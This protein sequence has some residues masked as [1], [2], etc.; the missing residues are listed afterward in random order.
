MEAKTTAGSDFITTDIFGQNPFERKGEMYFFNPAVV[1][2]EKVVEFFNDEKSINLIF[3]KGLKKH[4]AK[5]PKDKSV[6]VAHIYKVF[7]DPFLGGV[8]DDSPSAKEINKSF[9]EMNDIKFHRQYYEFMVKPSFETILK[10]VASVKNV[11]DVEINEFLYIFCTHFFAQELFV[12]EEV[13]GS[14]NKVEFFK[15]AYN[16]LNAFNYAFIGELP[17]DRSHAYFLVWED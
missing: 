10:D 4:L 9:T 1:S 7:D 5:Q 3:P 14:Y 16:D 17:T 8:P 15:K 6:I 13:K 12:S 11:D 2:M